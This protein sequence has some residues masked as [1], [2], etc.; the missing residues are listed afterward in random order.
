MAFTSVQL[1]VE[2]HGSS[3]TS[4]GCFFQDTL[5]IIE[6]QEDSKHY[7]PALTH[8]NPSTWFPM[9]TRVS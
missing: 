5:A 2:H 8:I 6:M 9:R 4:S 1:I 7:P 3:Q